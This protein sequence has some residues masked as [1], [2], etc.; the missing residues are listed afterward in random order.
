[1]VLDIFQNATAKNIPPTGLLNDKNVPN[2]IE[3]VTGSIS[4]YEI[5]KL[6]NINW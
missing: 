1:M 6:L 5:S 3:T 2:A 4:K